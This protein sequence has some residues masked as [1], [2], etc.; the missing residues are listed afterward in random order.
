MNT[1]DLVKVEEGTDDYIWCVVVC[2]G[3]EIDIDSRNDAESTA[4]KIRASLHAAYPVIR[5]SVLSEALQDAPVSEERLL[6]IRGFAI[7][8]TGFDVAEQLR[9]TVEVIT[10]AVTLIDHLRAQVAWLAREQG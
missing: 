3:E 2:N 8:L 7:G 4:K 6:E 9:T 5:E 10:D 1:D